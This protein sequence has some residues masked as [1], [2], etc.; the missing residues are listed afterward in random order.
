MLLN[1]TELPNALAVAE[2]IRAAVEALAIPHQTSSAAKVVTVS[3]GVAWMVPCKGTAPADLVQAADG[4][5]Y[6]AK[7]SGRNRVAAAGASVAE[8]SS[9]S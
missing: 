8:A 7:K 4:A 2:K 6:E 3:M 5:L 9:A 1:A